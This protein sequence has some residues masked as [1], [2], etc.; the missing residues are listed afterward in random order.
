[1]MFLGVLVEA[2]KLIQNLF[3]NQK[4]KRSLMRPLTH[5]LKNLTTPLVSETPLVTAHT[6]LAAIRV[7]EQTG[8]GS[9]LG[10]CSTFT[11]SNS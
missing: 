2:Q 7:H 3:S 4:K 10:T 11:C 5:L 1:M 8:G 6:L 9:I